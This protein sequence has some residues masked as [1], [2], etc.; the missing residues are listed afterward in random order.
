MIGG[1]KN[2]YFDIPQKRYVGITCLVRYP[3]NQPKTEDFWV[4]LSVEQNTE[5]ISTVIIQLISTVRGATCREDMQVDFFYFARYEIKTKFKL[6]RKITQPIIPRNFA[7]KFWEI[8]LTD[9][10]RCIHVIKFATFHTFLQTQLQILC[11]VPFDFEHDPDRVCK[12]Y[13][14]W[15]G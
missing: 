2:K 14:F 12:S 11:V 7:N 10:W 4:H 8:L 6:F 9:F 13:L 3:N 5:S 15:A 1:K